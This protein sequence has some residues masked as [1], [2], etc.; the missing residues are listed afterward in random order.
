[1]DPI[2]PPELAREERLPF[3]PGVGCLLSFLAGL[4]C[5]GAFFFVLWFNQQ[6]QIVYS[7][8]PYRVTRVWILRGAEGKGLGFSTSR[9]LPGATTDRIC[10]RTEVRFFF[11]SGGMPEANTDYCDCYARSESGWAFAGACPG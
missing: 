11:I 5:A 9:P 2:G 1:M 8:E 7:P 10:A 3:S 4:A 6:G